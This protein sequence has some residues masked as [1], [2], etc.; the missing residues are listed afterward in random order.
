MSASFFPFFPF[1]FDLRV[2]GVLLTFRIVLSFPLPFTG[3]TI[4]AFGSGAL[5]QLFR[6]LA[7][8]AVFSVFLPGF[9]FRVPRSVS[10]HCASI[11]DRIF[12]VVLIPRIFPPAIA[13]FQRL[14][15]PPLETA[16]R[17]CFVPAFISFCFCACY[18]LVR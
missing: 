11:S 13:L 10:R 5:P 3:R 9:R 1:F 4:K 2:V 17:H 18:T 7:E 12:S 15:L 16:P 8:P 6:K 14:S